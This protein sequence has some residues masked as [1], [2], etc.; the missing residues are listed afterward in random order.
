[1]V[2]A[3]GVDKGKQAS[4]FTITGRGGLPP[5]PT[6]SLTTEALTSFESEDEVNQNRS[7]L[8]NTTE[9][10]EAEQLLPPARG[11]YFN[12]QGTLVLTANIP[13]AS[14]YDSRTNNPDCNSISHNQ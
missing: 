4:Q 10:S 12:P 13:N 8:T 3:C 7:N 6:S 11:W 1:M 14:P 2:S 9:D 5:R